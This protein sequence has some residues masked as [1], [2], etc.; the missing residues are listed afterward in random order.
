MKVGDKVVQM[1]AG[2]ELTELVITKI[3]DGIIHCGAWTFDE[4]TGAEI[5]PPPLVQ[6]SF[7]KL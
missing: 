7:I 2:L 4:A 6:S 3:E 1:I 5:D